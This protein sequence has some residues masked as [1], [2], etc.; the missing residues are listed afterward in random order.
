MTIDDDIIAP[1]LA[2]FFAITLTIGHQ[3]LTTKSSIEPLQHEL[4]QSYITESA[5]LREVDTLTKEL[6]SY[7]ATQSSLE[8]LGASPSQAKAV[9]QAAGSY[10]L[11]PKF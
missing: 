2:A 9:I 5:A 11:D 10:H 7:H 4:D 1:I 3:T 6:Q 8:S